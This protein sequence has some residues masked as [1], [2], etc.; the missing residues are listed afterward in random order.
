MEPTQV[1]ALQFVLSLTGYGL[2]ALWFVGPWL[3]RKPERDALALLVL[4]HAFRHVGASL[5]VPGLVGDH[6]PRRFAVGTAAG[7]LFTVALALLA[8]VVLRLG[9]RHA[10]KAVWVMNVVGSADLLANLAR[11]ARLAVAP[12]LGAAWFGPAFVVPLMLVAH[13]TL[14][15]FLA[16]G[17]A[18]ALQ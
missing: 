17:R 13:A 7:D 3:A 18:A 10:R 6:L 4:P 2:A 11:G 16:R 5:L 8:L 9:W 12:E 1:L 15:V 14:F